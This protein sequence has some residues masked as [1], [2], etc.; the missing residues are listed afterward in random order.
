MNKAVI[1]GDIIAYTS[2]NLKQKEILEKELKN[3]FR[4]LNNRYNIFIRLVNGDYLE[5]VIEKPEK[6]L[7]IALLIKTFV[8]SLDFNQSNNDKR[9]K[10]F[11][12]YG[13]RLAIAIGNLE[14]FE[15][16]KGIID[17]EAIYKAGRLI[18]EQSTHESKKIH[19]KQSL[20]FF[21]ENDDLNKEMDTIFNLVDFILNKATGKQARIIHRKIWGEN[22]KEIARKF[23]ISRSVVNRQAIAGGW[24]PIKKTLQYYPEKILKVIQ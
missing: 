15:P 1:T 11:N 8:K 2:L 20:Y 17:G 14:R 10:F 16:E 23:N 12:N 6:S 19:I 5:C 24:H 21:S 18:N 3:L 4:I 7:E 13:I 22:E 9:L